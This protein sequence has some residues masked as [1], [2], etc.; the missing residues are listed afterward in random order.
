MLIWTEAWSLA[1]IILLEAEHFLGTY[2][3]TC[4]VSARLRWYIDQSYFSSDERRLVKCIIT[5]LTWV[6]I[7]G[8]FSHINMLLQDRK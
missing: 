4:Y 3:S 5:K 8:L 1:L 6:E 2:N 7:W